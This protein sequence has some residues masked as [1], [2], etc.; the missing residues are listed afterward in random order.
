MAKEVGK[1]IEAVTR[2]VD[3]ESI[4]ATRGELEST[5]PQTPDLKNMSS[6]GDATDAWS[7]L[8]TSEVDENL[9][10]PNLAKL[11]SKLDT[12]RSLIPTVD[13]GSDLRTQE[14]ELLTQINAINSQSHQT[15]KGLIDPNDTIEQFDANDPYQVLKQTYI[16]EGRYNEK[17][18]TQEELETLLN[19]QDRQ[20]LLNIDNRSGLKKSLAGIR[21][22]L[23]GIFNKNPKINTYG[24]KSAESY[25]QKAVDRQ[26][27]VVSKIKKA[28]AEI[29]ERIDSE[30]AEKVAVRSAV[31]KIRTSHN[32]EK[33]AE[34]DWT[35]GMAA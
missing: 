22:T 7:K 20:P 23:D 5:K 31:T 8:P 16:Q 12:V 15:E 21:I 30:S 3:S 9:E 19:S 13:N 34:D 29:Q 2:K 33:G 10:D 26:D 28:P 35:R 25:K 14:L 6:S 24:A 4:R 18:T 17:G 11:R 32:P 27:Y 1:R